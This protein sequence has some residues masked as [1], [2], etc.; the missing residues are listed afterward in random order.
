MCGRRCAANAAT[1]KPAARTNNGCERRA[2]RRSPSKNSRMQT[3]DYTGC[4]WEQR[5]GDKAAVRRNGVRTAVCAALLLSALSVAESTGCQAQTAAEQNA[6]STKPDAPRPQ[7]A[8][9][10]SK[11]NEARAEHHFWD[12]EN[13]WLFAGLGAARTL[14]Y[15]STLNMRRRG[16][17]EILLTN[18]VVDNHAAFA[19]IEAAGTATSI[20][21][22]YLFH[23][24]GHHQLERWTSI[25]HI[26]LTT[27]GAVRNY[28]L[29]TAHV[30]PPPSSP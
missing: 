5:L 3:G 16:R 7:S 1:E 24:Y 22:S 20:G 15:A 10:P 23:R 28:C 18:D 25:V 11:S 4:V 19:A 29:K 26:G 6:A 21:V 14:D 8:S 9:K 30:V 13:D 12:K 2:L 27:T 17:Q